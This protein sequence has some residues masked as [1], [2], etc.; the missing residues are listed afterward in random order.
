MFHQQTKDK[1]DNTVSG[2]L[3]NS[4]NL[5]TL[6]WFHVC[7]VRQVFVTELSKVHHPKDN[8]SDQKGNLPAK[9][10]GSCNY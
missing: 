7:F 8:T 10:F 6:S 5:Q 4:E 9:D 3:E 1:T 2:N